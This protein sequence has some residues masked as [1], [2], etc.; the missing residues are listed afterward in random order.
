MLHPTHGSSD[1]EQDQQLYL[2]CAREEK[3]VRGAACSDRLPAAASI[4]GNA[5]GLG[6]AESV[7]GGRFVLVVASGLVFKERRGERERRLSRV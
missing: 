4:A 1:E 6:A 5:G 3:G 2:E 7:R